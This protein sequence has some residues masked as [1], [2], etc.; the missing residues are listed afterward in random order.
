MYNQ[1]NKLNKTL[2]SSH[3]ELA[4]LFEDSSGK[5]AVPILLWF[6]GV[7][8]IVVLLLWFLFFRG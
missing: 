8:G 1:T 4:N 2:K 6:L 3:R 7:P 5:V